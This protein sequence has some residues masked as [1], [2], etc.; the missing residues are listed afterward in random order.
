MKDDLKE[1]WEQRYNE[2]KESGFSK[3][4]WCQLNK[5]N[6]HQLYYWF[7]RL[8]KEEKS[9]EIKWLPLK[10][11]NNLSEI[12]DDNTISI[13]VGKCNVD[14]KPNFDTDQLSKIIKVLSSLC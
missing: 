7:K 5:L 13:R 9:K 8:N 2:W 1:V 12:K 3:S 14:V 6:I 4:K 10:V 11:E